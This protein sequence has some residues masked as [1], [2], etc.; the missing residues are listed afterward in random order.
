LTADGIEAL[1][2]DFRGWLEQAAE[3]P[4]DPAAEEPGFALHTLVAEFTA[5]RQEVNLLTRATRTQ[6]E[7]NAETLRQLG[8]AIEHLQE[9]EEIDADQAAEALRPLLKMLVDVY[10]VLA[11]ARREVQRV[12]AAVQTL[13]GQEEPSSEAGEPA[14]QP[15]APVARRW[16]QWWSGA[17]AET[18]N[19][20]LEAQLA[21]ERGRVQQ[22]RNAAA[23]R[24]QSAEQV[25]RFFMSVVTGYTMSLQRIDRALQQHGLE[26]IACVAEPFDPECMEVAEVV[27]EPGRTGTVVLE[28]VRRGYRWRGRVFRPA[29]VRVARP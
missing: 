4:E 11:L 6:Q 14:A 22:L 12:E 18:A 8:Q 17:G 15:M 7:Q 24:R 21:R 25:Q 29:Q 16:W 10:D 2:R 20:D 5:L 23:A 19:A 3:E 13:L 9:A 27:S 28:E 26:V 1:L